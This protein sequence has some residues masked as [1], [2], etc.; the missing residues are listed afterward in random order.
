MSI[1][2]EALIG[3]GAG[4]DEAVDA[5]GAGSEGTERTLL[6]AALLKR[7]GLPGGVPVPVPLASNGIVFPSGMLTA[8]A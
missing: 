3:E 8:A 2:K 1:N 5:T 4:A 6:A 7:S